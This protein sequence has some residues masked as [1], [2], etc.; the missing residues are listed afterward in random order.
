[1]LLKSILSAVFLAKL[2]LPMNIKS[3]KSQIGS[4]QEIVPIIEDPQ[5]V[6][7]NIS[8]FAG[9]MLTFSKLFNTKK[10]LLVGIDEIE[11][12]TDSN[13]AA[14]L[15][16][17]ILQELIKKE[18]KIIVTTHHKKLASSM[19]KNKNVELLA[20]IYNEEEQ[21]PTY[22]FLQGTIGKSF[23]FETALRYNIPSFVVAKAKE[24]YGNDYEDLSGLIEKSTRLEYEMEQKKQELEDKLEKVQN[25]K[26]DLYAQKEKMHNE[27]KIQ[28]EK[29]EQNLNEAIEYARQAIKESS[30]NAHKLLDKA[31][32]VRKVA[33][34]ALPDK[35]KKDKFSKGD[36]VKYNSMQGQIVAIKGSFATIQS[37]ILRL[38]VP[39]RELK[40]SKIIPE[41]SKIKIDMPKSKTASLSL[42]LHGVRADEAMDKL[43]DFLSNAAMNDL[44]EVTIYHGMGSGRLA[45]LV[46]EFLDIHPCI[47]EYR[48]APV[49]MGGYGAT[50]AVLS[51][52]K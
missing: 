26:N 17:A 51:M 37:D 9:R 10:S 20:A 38:K 5:N 49:N 33:S 40:H 36:T 41:K 27:Y 21:K 47:L 8:T 23:A 11:L 2:I 42:D 35:L 30:Q 39:I 48:D 32:K 18:N 50:I 46:K 13:E 24:Y 52:S 28:K 16:E 43:D 6:K 19:A 14:S 7:E 15:F 22:R 29:M 34:I 44:S 25:I 1:M 45:Y 12:G 31:H 3:S 4:F